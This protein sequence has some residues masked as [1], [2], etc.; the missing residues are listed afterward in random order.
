MEVPCCS[1]HPSGLVVRAGWAGKEG[2]RRQRWQCSPPDGAAS[3]RFFEVLPRIEAQSDHC[4][5]CSTALEAW[6]GQPA[7]RGYVWSAREVAAALVGVARG[8]TYRAAALRGRSSSDGVLIPRTIG[9]RNAVTAGAFAYQDV[10]GQ[11][12]LT[13]L[14]EDPAQMALAKSPSK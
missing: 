1:T 9:A 13:E 8:D 6:E 3:H 7:P 12:L 11:P 14:C 2:R 10:P 5:E 4:L